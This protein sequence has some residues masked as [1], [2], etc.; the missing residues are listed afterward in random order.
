MASTF[1]IPYPSPQSTVPSQTPIHQSTP[2]SNSTFSWYHLIS[3]AF[4]DTLNDRLSRT[5]RIAA[6]PDDS[7]RKRWDQLCEEKGVEAT[8]FGLDDDSFAFPVEEDLFGGG[9]I[10]FGIAFGEPEGEDINIKSMEG[11]KALVKRGRGRPRKQSAPVAAAQ[12]SLKKIEELSERQWEGGIKPQK[13][14]SEAPPLAPVAR[15]GRPPKRKSTGTA[16]L[17]A[18]ATA[19]IHTNEPQP[20]PIPT[21][22]PKRSRKPLITRHIPLSSNSSSSSSSD[23]PSQSHSQSQSQSQSQS[24]FFFTTLPK[25]THKHATTSTLPFSFRLNSQQRTLTSDKL[26]MLCARARVRRTKALARD[27][28]QQQQQQQQQA[29]GVV[30]PTGAW[31]KRNMK[32]MKKIR[33]GLDTGDDENLEK[34]ARDEGEGG[35][36]LKGSKRKVVNDGEALGSL[37]K[38]TKRSRRKKRKTI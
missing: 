22:K 16:D 14:E 1:D 30:L 27:G 24:P 21:P 18:G 34:D 2:S 28:G 5:P 23:Q 12:K 4:R 8:P 38:N 31:L 10:G 17:P 3:V 37:A 26:V 15:R 29:K 32:V 25:S 20:P 19:S 11:A 13:Q 35:K 6:E 9:D 7:I 36:Q 33:K